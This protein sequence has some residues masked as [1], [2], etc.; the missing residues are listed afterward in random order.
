MVFLLFYLITWNIWL[1]YINIA[2]VAPA[3]LYNPLAKIIGLI[4]KNITDFIGGIIS[5]II[6]S[7]VYFIVLTP[8]AIIRKNT[9]KKVKQS[10][11]SYFI[12]RAKIYKKEDFD[13]MW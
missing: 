5:K 11:E 1:I 12:D 7:I 9:V 3:L 4:I 2:I 13:K 6:L 10:D 8:I